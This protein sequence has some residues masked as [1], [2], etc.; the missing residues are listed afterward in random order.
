MKLGKPKDR[1][2]TNWVCKARKH[3]E[4]DLWHSPSAKDGESLTAQS[5]LMLGKDIKRESLGKDISNIVMRTGAFCQNCGKRQFGAELVT[6]DSQ[7]LR[8]QCDSQWISSC[9]CQCWEI[10]FKDGGNGP[11]LVSW[12]KPTDPI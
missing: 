2:R 11:D 12:A 5:L 3:K 7:Q 6:F 4:E 1:L 10:V 9:K 8:M